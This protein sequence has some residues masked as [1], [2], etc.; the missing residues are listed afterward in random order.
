M[1]EVTFEPGKNG[2]NRLLDRREQGGRQR[3][4]TWA[5]VGKGMGS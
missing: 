5:S 4:E 2:D 3:Q 1:E